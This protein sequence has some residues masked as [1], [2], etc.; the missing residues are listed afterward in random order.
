[1]SLVKPARLE[2]TNRV[3]Q[4]IRT[5]KLGYVIEGQVIEMNLGD[6][7]PGIYFLKLTD[8]TTTGLQQLVIQQ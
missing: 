7:V 8:G 1:M 5:M 6:L 3:G 2:I 4:V